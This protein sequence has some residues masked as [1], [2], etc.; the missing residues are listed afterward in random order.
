VFLLL[1]LHVV[2]RRFGFQKLS[3]TARDFP[4]LGTFLVVRLPPLLKPQTELAEA[5]PA[6]QREV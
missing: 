3:K 5:D 2:A 4:I 1:I 6:T